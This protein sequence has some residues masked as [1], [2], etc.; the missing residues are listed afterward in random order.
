MLS[1]LWARHFFKTDSSWGVSCKITSPYAFS[2]TTFINPPELST[3]N[4]K[5]SHPRLWNTMLFICIQRV[6]KCIERA[7]RKEA[8]PTC[9]SPLLFQYIHYLFYT[10]QYFEKKHRVFSLVFTF[11]NW[12][13]WSFYSSLLLSLNYSTQVSRNSSGS[14][15]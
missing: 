12:K 7:S 13:Q 1:Y 10:H 11:N 9:P 5:T 14:K 6:E 3:W 15:Y 2:C 4:I 8:R